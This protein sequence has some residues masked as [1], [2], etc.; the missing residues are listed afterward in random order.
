VFHVE[1]VGGRPALVGVL[2]AA[3]LKITIGVMQTVT[4]PAG[5]VQVQLMFLPRDRNDQKLYV[6]MVAS[7]ERP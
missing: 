1:T 4:F 2:G 5:D 6:A 3:D 7:I